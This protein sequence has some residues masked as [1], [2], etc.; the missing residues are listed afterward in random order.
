MKSQYNNVNHKQ[1]IL[2]NVN[3][4]D[5]PERI[6]FFGLWADHGA[7]VLERHLFQSLDENV[8]CYVRSE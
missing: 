2:H 7:V 4:L 5:F 1:N 3:L 8:K 6:C